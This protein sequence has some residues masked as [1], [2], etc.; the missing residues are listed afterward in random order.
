MSVKHPGK[1]NLLGVLVDALDYESA[2]GTIV[3]AAS[4][5]QPL[6]VTALAVHGVMTG[7]RDRVHRHR[8]NSLDLVTP[9][10]QPVRWALNIAHHTGL[11]DRVYGPTLMLRICEQAAAQGLGV[12]LYG[13]R[14]EV[15]DGLATSLQRQFP[16]LRIAGAEPSTFGTLTAGER[17]EL[18]ARIRQSAA[19]ILFAGLGCPRQEVFVYEIR[20]AL[21]MPVV[22][23]GAAFDYHSGFR[24]EPP[25]WMQ[26]AGLQWLHRLAHEPGRLWKRYLFHNVSFVA[27]FALQWTGL[28]CPDPADTDQPPHPLSLG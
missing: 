25:L 19:N 12:Y 6:G 22:A 17:T 18:I 11:K 23:V 28:R 24:A 26:R 21:S 9:D 16:A 7:V 27:R 4:L 5:R 13:S 14:R 20:D 2:V 15:V 10:G 8:L 3:E 1:R